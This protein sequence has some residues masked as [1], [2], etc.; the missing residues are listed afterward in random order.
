MT[1]GPLLGLGLPVSGA[2]AT[3]TAMR[4]FAQRAEA[5]G[6]ASLWTFQRLLGPAVT[7]DGDVVDEPGNPS[8][9]PPDDPAY[10]AVHDATLPLAH[11]A[12]CTERIR[13]GTATLCAPFIAPALLA[14]QMTT[15]DHLCA[16]RLTVGLGIGWQP[17]E[18]AAAGVPFEHRGA[19]MDEYLRCLVA[20]WTQDPA[21]FEGRFY[22]VPRSRNGPLPVQR[23]HPP[24]LVG[25]S[26]PAALRRAG[27]LAQ[28]W[29]ASSGQP[30]DGLEAAIGH[31]RDGA[32]AAGRDPDGLKV[33]LRAVVQLTDDDPGPQRRPFHGA[34]EQVRDDIAALHARGVTEVLADLNLTPG[35]GSPDA[36]PAT[37]AEQADRII[38]ELAPARLP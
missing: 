11:V 3:P 32:L 22:T 19:R 33:L 30:L 12:A 29:I 21:E 9:R 1:G 36:D 38:R 20:L 34:P 15:L 2:W 7:R 17:H 25:G 14:K 26:A 27:A 28:G 23:P 13:L 4:A 31:V 16:G 35:I 8:S 37:A 24:L 6:Y 10:L 5:L 18:Y